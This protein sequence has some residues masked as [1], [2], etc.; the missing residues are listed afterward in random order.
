LAVVGNHV[1]DAVVGA[2]APDVDVADAIDCACVVEWE[3]EGCGKE[4]K[5]V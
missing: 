3:K 1:R 4:K 5:K 2:C